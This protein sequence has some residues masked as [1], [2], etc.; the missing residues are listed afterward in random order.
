[1][2][3]LK[4]IGILL[5]MALGYTMMLARVESKPERIINV[6]IAIDPV[7]FE[8]AESLMKE[9]RFTEAIA[10]YKEF[11]IQNPDSE[12]VPLAYYRMGQSYRKIS[13][14]DL[15]LQQYNKII[16]DYPAF[17]FLPTVFVE[18]A[19]VH[20]LN[21]DSPNKL[22]TLQQ[23]IGKWP[24]T[25]RAQHAHFLH[26]VH[27]YWDKNYR[28]AI[29]E[30]QKILDIQKILDNKTDAQMAPW[31]A[32]ALVFTARSYWKLQQHEKALSILATR[33]DKFGPD[34]ETQLMIGH[35]FLS[36]MRY[37]EAIAA[38]QQMDLNYPENNNLPVAK[39]GIA[40]TLEAQGKI[41]EAIKT[42][43]KLGDSYPSWAGLA[44]EH[45]N[46]LSARLS[47]IE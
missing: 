36:A 43:R 19:V 7:S 39:V 47:I 42:Y 16:S 35:V 40:R 6:E 10:N 12:K 14:F 28:Q 38:Y 2:F 5:I 18:K 41:E 3:R 32:E 23:I 25:S 46:R 29:T 22:A 17:S 44:Q 11:I 30:F 13:N 34:A 9:G 37:H 15:A 26:G 21:R 8:D 20:R 31:S 27:L 24:N 45:I 1:M 4:I 33:L